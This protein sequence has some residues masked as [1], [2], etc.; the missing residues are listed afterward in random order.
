MGKVDHRE[1]FLESINDGVLLVLLVAPISNNE[2]A[3]FSEG[4][5][6]QFIQRFSLNFDALLGTS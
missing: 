4:K 2:I 6:V 1:S 5:F 3:S